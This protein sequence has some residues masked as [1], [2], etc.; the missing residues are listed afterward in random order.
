MAAQTQIGPW[1]LVATATRLPY[2]SGEGVV[3]VADSA[4]RRQ[5][6]F[7]GGWSIPLGLLLRREW[8]HIGDPDFRHG[9]LIDCYQGKPGARA[10]MFRASK[11]GGATRIYIHPLAQGIDEMMNNSFAAISP[12]GQ[13][14][15]SGEW[16]TMSR[17]LVFPTPMLNPAA[18]TTNLPLAATIDLDRAVRNV[19]GAAFLD[20]TTLVCSTDDPGPDLWPVTQQLLQVDLDRPLD[21][22]PVGA[23]VTC[24]GPLGVQS[25]CQG[26]FEVEGIDYDDAT[27][28]LRVVV[29]P[30][31]PC[32]RLAVAV[33]TYR[34]S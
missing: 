8:V 20:D 31:S 33:Y 14:M 26:T 17:L 5:L 30:P 16:S 28:D 7:R 34:R 11:I 25:R 24:L 1:Q 4:G 27:G 15:V 12:D 6:R 10:K 3:T 29:I 19:Q 32:K 13:W 9:V 2:W 22:R 18:A 23:K 21:G